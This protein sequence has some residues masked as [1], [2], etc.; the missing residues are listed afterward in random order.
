VIR[1]SSAEIQPPPSIVQSNATQDSITGVV[2][3]G[4]TTERL[5]VMLDLEKLFSNEE[6]EFLCDMET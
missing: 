6:K 2:N 1:I 5:L 4:S 3:H